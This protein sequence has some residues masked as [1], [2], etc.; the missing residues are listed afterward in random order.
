MVAT[1]VGPVTQHAQSVSINVTGGSATSAAGASKISDED[2]A[3]ALRQS[4]AQSGLFARISAA[5]QADYRLDLQIVRLE[6]PMIGLSMTVTIEVTWRLARQSDHQTVWQKSVTSTYTA[7]MGEAFAGVTR[8][9]HATEGAARENIKDAIGQ[10]SAL[11]L[12]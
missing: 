1:P 3:E 12:P 6:Q 2:F 7:K 4:I 10:M 9:R 5:N 11:S 8:L